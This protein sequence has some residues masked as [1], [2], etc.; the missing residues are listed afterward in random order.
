MPSSYRRQKV[1]KRAAIYHWLSVPLLTQFLLT[2]V[3]VSAPNLFAGSSRMS[4]TLHHP[5]SLAPC[6]YVAGLQENSVRMV[7]LQG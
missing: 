7:M 6:M 2:Y 1:L 4:E 5:G 3:K